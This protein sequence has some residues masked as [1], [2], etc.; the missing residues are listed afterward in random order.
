M[1]KDIILN[2]IKKILL[3]NN[4]KISK[5]NFEKINIFNEETIDSFQLLSIITDIER[6]F[7]IKFSN[8]FIQSS[9]KNTIEKIVDLIKKK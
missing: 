6:S 4:F 9:K 7:K 1:K 3:K 5:K 2:N 8:K